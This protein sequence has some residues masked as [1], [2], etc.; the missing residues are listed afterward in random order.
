MLSEPVVKAMLSSQAPL[1][2]G[3]ID[4]DIKLLES[5]WVLKSI[6]ALP[7]SFCICVLF[8]VSICSFGGRLGVRCS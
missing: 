8:I 6:E 5:M 4:G 1:K 3:A 2:Q 7:R